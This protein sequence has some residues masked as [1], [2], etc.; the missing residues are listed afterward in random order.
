[1]RSSFTP[2]QWEMYLQSDIMGEAELEFRKN[3]YTGRPAGS[4]EFVEWA[5]SNLGRRLAPQKGGRPKG[6]G[7]A[8]G[9][10]TQAA[11]F[12]PE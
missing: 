7:V 4:P 6:S 9:A 1:M 8:D 10:P 12:A 3:T 5:E 2:E 11:L